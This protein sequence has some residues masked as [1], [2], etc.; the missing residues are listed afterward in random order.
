MAT[1]MAT[2]MTTSINLLEDFWEELAMRRLRKGLTAALLSAM[3]VIVLMGDAGALPAFA[4]KYETSCVTCHEAFPRLNSVG[5]A[6]RING[7]KFVDDELYIKEEP[8][9]MGDEAYKRLW[10]KKAIWPSDIPGLAPLS[11]IMTSDYDIDLG[12]TKDARSTFVFPR[13]LKLLGAGKFGE[14]VSFFTEVGFQQGEGGG[15]AHGESSEE[16]VQ[17]SIEGWLQFEDLFGWE[18]KFNLRVGTVGMHELGLFTARDHNR[19]SVNPYLYSTW[20]IPL[21]DEHTLG[22]LLNESVSVE[23]N[24]FIVHAQPGIELN[25]FGHR[26]RYAVGVVNGTGSVSDNNSEKD[27]YVQLAYKFGGRGFDGESKEKGAGIS[28]GDPWRDDS[29]TLSLFGYRGTGTIKLAGQEREDDFWRFGPGVQ[30]KFHD[31][32]LGAGYILGENDRPYGAISTRSVDSK[33]WFLE[34][35]YFVYPWLIPYARYEGLD[36]DLASGIPSLFIQENQNRQRV[37]FGAKALVRANVSLA[38]EGLLYTK[39]ERSTKNFLQRGDTGDANQATVSLSYG[40]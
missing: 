15:H 35:S 16:G 21:P 14:N 27:L 30:W 9:E 3:A 2:V 5:E 39:D 18:D 36:L 13:S 12:G 26:W 4:R 23:G 25:G 10:P 6:F 7:Y 28:S 11:I 37:V 31:L 22:D 32:Q 17:T 29:V 38:V 20:S 40:F 33:A 34:A 8:V 24:P 1:V 19:L